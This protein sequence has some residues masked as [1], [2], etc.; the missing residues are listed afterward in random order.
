MKKIDKYGIIVIIGM[1][2]IIIGIVISW[3]RF[4]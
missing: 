4:K 2:A 1:L 3:Q